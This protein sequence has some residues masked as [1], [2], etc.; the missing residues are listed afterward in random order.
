MTHEAIAYGGDAALSEGHNVPLVEL[1]YRDNETRLG[2]HSQY[3]GAHPA[4][5]IR[6]STSA[7]HTFATADLTGL[8]QSYHYRDFQHDAVQR[9]I[10]W[11]KG[12][13]EESDTLVIYDV[14]DRASSTPT[15]LPC[16]FQLQLDEAPTLS[17]ANAKVQLGD[18][19]LDIA[20]VI[21]SVNLE[22]RVPEGSPGVYPGELYNHRLLAHPN[23]PERAVRFVSVLRASDAGTQAPLKAVG[24]SDATW[25]GVQVGSEIFLAPV[26]SLQPSGG[27][28]NGADA[29]I[30]D[31]SIRVWVAGF[32]PER[33]Y[34]A[35]VSSSGASR[36][37]SIVPGSGVM[38]DS[39]GLIAL[40]VDASG[41]V[42][43]VFSP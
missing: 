7:V 23:S 43:S 14:I 31:G 33:Q 25:R 8:Y 36:T 34:A 19:E 28:A 5:I 32:E 38:A 24:L 18:Q 11:L 30:P 13:E 15:S 26:A 9:S 3:R 40:T 37:L 20:V 4:R 21:P 6:L 27:V 1:L 42:D 41:A 16:S 2:Q 17:D 10:L 35:T 39:A 12:G 29:S 22:A